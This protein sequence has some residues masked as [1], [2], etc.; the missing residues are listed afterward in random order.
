MGEK[1]PFS[2]WPQHL[3]N[4]KPGEYN[5][6]LNGDFPDEGLELLFERKNGEPFWGLA[7]GA[8]LLNSNGEKIGYLFSISDITQRKNAEKALKEVSGRLIDTQEK[9]RQK[10]SQ[11]LHDSIGAKLTSIKYG[12]EKI[13]SDLDDTAKQLHAPIKDLIHVT[14]QTIDETHRILKS[15]RPSVL[16]DLGLKAALRDLIRDYISIYSHLDI[17]VKLQIDEKDV[18]EKIKIL[19]YRVVQEALH[20]IA[21]HSGATCVW[22]SLERSEKHVLLEISDDGCGFD[23]RKK[24]LSGMGLATIQERVAFL[25]DRCR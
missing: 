12:L 21:K 4:R 13:H 10:I 9:E 5:C 17:K 20:N 2:Y 1:Y 25:A 24:E 22:L 11:E 7:H 15:L 8:L 14:R 6:L 3:I 16:D 18:P 19:V 23:I